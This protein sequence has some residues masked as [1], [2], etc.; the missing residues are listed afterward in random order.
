MD[1]SVQFSNNEKKYIGICLF[2]FVLFVI[3]LSNKLV[4]ELVTSKWF[5]ALINVCV[6]VYCIVEVV[7]SSFVLYSALTFIVRWKGILHLY[8]ACLF[9]SSFFF[10]KKHI[11]IMVVFK[12]NVMHVCCLVIMF[13]ASVPQARGLLRDYNKNRYVYIII[14]IYYLKAFFFYCM[15]KMIVSSST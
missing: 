15:I 2:C 4:V 8:T 7:V 14:I 1:S 3:L 6:F 5:Y 11:K 10:T 13:Y 9:C 12:L